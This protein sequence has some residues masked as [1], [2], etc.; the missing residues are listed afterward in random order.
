MVLKSSRK[1]TVIFI[2]KFSGIFL[3]FLTLFWGVI[4]GN[5]IRAFI[6]ATFCSLVIFVIMAPWILP[7]DI[8]ADDKYLYIHQYIKK[9]KVPF[10]EIKMIELY[11]NSEARGAPV[12]RVTKNSGERIMQGMGILNNEKTEL[13]ISILNSH[14][15]KIYY[16][17]LD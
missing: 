12:I 14:N 16:T 17:K 4:Y 7:L 2:A 3:I 8:T 11:M 10:I 9:Y 1:N 5:F 6:F 15:I 13:L